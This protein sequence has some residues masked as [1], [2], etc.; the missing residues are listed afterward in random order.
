MQVKAR[1]I[2]PATHGRARRAYGFFPDEVTPMGGRILFERLSSPSI[3]PTPFIR[4]N[5]NDGIVALPGCTSGPGSSCP[6]SE[7]AA[8]VKQRGE[9]AGDFRD[10]CRLGPEASSGLTF[11]R[12]P[13]GGGERIVKEEKVEWE[14]IL[15]L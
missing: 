14:G 1:R 13:E 12:Q 6:L 15:D 4:I 3:S 9:V 2:L 11:L 10:V 5:V 7:F 8:H